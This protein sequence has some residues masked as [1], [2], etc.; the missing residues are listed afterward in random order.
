MLLDDSFQY[1]RR[2]GMI[3]DSFGINDRNWALRADAKAIGF[4]P[5][6]QSFR[7]CEFQFFEPLLEEFPRGQALFF[8][9]ALGFGLI[10][11]KKNMPMIFLHTKALCRRLNRAW[12]R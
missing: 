8:R 10:R 12:P 2:A 4:R 9:R 1:F 5:I 7:A 11:A 6:D 3:P